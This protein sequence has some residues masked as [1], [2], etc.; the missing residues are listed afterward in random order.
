[1]GLTLVA[2]ELEQVG[3]PAIAATL[4]EKVLPL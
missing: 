2:A 3:S 4:I 1:M